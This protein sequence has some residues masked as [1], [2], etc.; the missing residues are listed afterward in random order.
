VT[1]KISR[2]FLLYVVK[3]AFCHYDKIPKLRF[4]FAYDFWACG[5]ENIMVDGG[6]VGWTRAKLLIS[7]KL[8]SK[9]KERKGPGS[10]YS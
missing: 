1:S 7:W 2:I 5:Q 9:E 8:R 3:S 4:I 6:G 10:Q